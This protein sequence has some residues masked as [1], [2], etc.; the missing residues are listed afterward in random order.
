MQVQH[1]ETRKYTRGNKNIL[2]LLIP[3]MART[4]SR[5]SSEAGPFP[6]NDALQV[7]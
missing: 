1:K 5:A 4:F 7:L 2:C 3:S 6:E